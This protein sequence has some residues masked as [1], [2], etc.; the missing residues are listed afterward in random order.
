MT[1]ITFVI[2]SFN[3]GHTIIRSLESIVNMSISF[4]AIVIDDASTDNTKEVVNKWINLKKLSNFI[5]YYSLKYNVGVTAAKNFG[6]YLSK[7]G[8][9]VFLDS[10]DMMISQKSNE[11][12]NTLV[13]YNNVPLI[14]FRCVDEKGIKIGKEFKEDRLLSLHDYVNNSSYGEALTVINKKKV[15]LD[16]CYPG[17][18]RGYEGIGCLRLIKNYGP[19]ILSN[20][21][22]RIYDRSG[23]NRL[24]SKSGML[25]RLSLI[26][27]GHRQLIKEFKAYLS[28]KNYLN[29]VLKIKLYFFLTIWK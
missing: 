12:Q 18:L 2:P 27:R 6:Y 3:R 28:W 22:I 4:E 23:E 13:Q 26:E 29:Y 1:L 20:L 21:Y 8:W 24:S 15:G 17:S 5:F 11:F 10:D 14:F 19:A 16:F 25:S 9:V 7:S